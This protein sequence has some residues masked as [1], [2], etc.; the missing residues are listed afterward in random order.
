MLHDDSCY[1]IEATMPVPFST[2]LAVPGTVKN[3]ADLVNGGS[4]DKAKLLAGLRLLREQLLGFAGMHVWLE[5]AKDR[6][7]LL[8]QAFGAL[9][10]LRYH[11]NKAREKGS[12][13]AEHYEVRDVRR[14]WLPIAKTWLSRL[15]VER[16]APRYVLTRTGLGQAT[17]MEEQR[18]DEDSGKLD[19]L[20]RAVDQLLTDWDEGK[21]EI[22][23]EARSVP[24][25]LAISAAIE[26]VESQVMDAMHRLDD[27]MKDV[28]SYLGT[29]CTEMYGALNAIKL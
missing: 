4:P 1:S 26:D 11:D 16:T 3:L 7:S 18:V 28:A 27:E 25:E 5:E 20:R 2:L 15:S 9:Q 22:R 10:E 12:F 8:Q 17:L 29:T 19:R 13:R 24:I 6:H 14:I 21:R 23:T